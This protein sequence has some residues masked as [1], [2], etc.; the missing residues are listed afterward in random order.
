[1]EIDS[2]SYSQIFY[3]C[4]WPLENGPF[5]M[6]VTGCVDEGGHIQKGGRFGVRDTPQRGLQN[7][8]ACL[9]PEEQGFPLG[10][11]STFNHPTITP[12]S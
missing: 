10:G 5:G 2:G 12:H 6:V 4:T 11:S 3:L 9:T 1:M 7:P 8:G